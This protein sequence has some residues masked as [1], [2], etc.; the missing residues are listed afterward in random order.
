MP[1]PF[2]KEFNR[3]LFPFFELRRAEI[4][5]ISFETLAPP[6]IPAGFRFSRGFLCSYPVHAKSADERRV[7]NLLHCP[8][9]SFILRRDTLSG[10]VEL[11]KERGRFM[12]KDDENVV[13]DYREVDTTYVFDRDLNPVV[14]NGAKVMAKCYLGHNRLFPLPIADYAFAGVDLA[15]T[16]AVV[17]LAGFLP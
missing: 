5:F 15:A 10:E 11:A 2:I 6:N 17:A 9:V 4:L 8:A 12:V 3:V 13:P 16:L 7:Y 1:E 14:G